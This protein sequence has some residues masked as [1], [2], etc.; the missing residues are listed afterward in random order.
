MSSSAVRK[1]DH[2]DALSLAPPYHCHHY[3]Y[4]L[5]YRTSESTPPEHGLSGAWPGWS[6]WQSN[7]GRWYATRSTDPNARELDAG[8]VR[9]LEASTVEDLS[10][11]LADQARR[12]EAA[13]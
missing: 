1:A 9:T 7:I 10:K 11:E 2:E 6:I 4:M 5:H 8:C 12:A 3:Q 13:A